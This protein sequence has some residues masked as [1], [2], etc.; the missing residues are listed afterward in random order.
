MSFNILDEN[1]RIELIKEINSVENKQR[2][3]ISLKQYEIF[4]DRLYQYV[5]EDLRKHFSEDTVNEMP[6]VSF[7]NFPRR[8]VKNLSSVYK[9]EPVRNFFNVNENQ[10]AALNKIYSS[11]EVDEKLKRANEFYNLQDQTHLYIVPKKGRLKIK[12]VLQHQ[13]DVIPSSSD[14]EEPEAYILSVFDKSKFLTYQFDK[15][16]TGR[17]GRSSI[18]SSLNFSRDL[19]IAD[20]N[21]FKKHV[22]VYVYWDKTYNFIFNSDGKI[23][24]PL[25]LLPYEREIKEEDILSPIPGVLPFVDIS[26]L[27]DNEYFVRPGL[28]I[29]DFGIQ[30]NSAFSDVWHISRMQGY[31]VGVLKGPEELMPEK[32]KI[33]PNYLL[34]LKTSRA[35]GVLSNGQD[36][37]FKYV[38]PSPDI[39]SSIKLLETM[40]VNFIS[41]RGIDPKEIAQDGSKSFS[42]ALERLLSMIDRFEASKDDFKLFRK[43]EI[44]LFNII[45]AWI[46]SN[47]PELDEDYRF[48]IPDDAY[49]N[50]EF[51]EPQMLM[52]KQEEVNYWQSRRESRTASRIDAIMD[53]YKVNRE[54]AIK[55]AER[56]DQEE[57][58]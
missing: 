5:I 8:I 16:A 28:V 46:N 7:I 57:S 38:S 2:K 43:K 50:I 39:E 17:L 18:G 26:K 47:S 13:I 52:T 24:D 55:I 33:G 1:D 3:A 36:I 12:N 34:R 35:D 27:K 21:D 6:I 41:S 40:L 45:K 53:I 22:D 15:S 58:V 11:I 54:E 4:N 51:H 23:L 31:S 19:T 48:S 42:S 49:I 44:E 25:T 9:K 30:Y 10:S 37:D 14:P 56:I 32:L 29:T 20:K